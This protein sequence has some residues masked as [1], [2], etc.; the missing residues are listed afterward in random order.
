MM[1]IGGSCLAVLKWRAAIGIRRGQARSAL[2]HR[3]AKPCNA[4]P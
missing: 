4:M 2:W 3:Y 1:F